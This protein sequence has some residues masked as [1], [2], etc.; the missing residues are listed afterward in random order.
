MAGCQRGVSPQLHIP[1]AAKWS[2]LPLLG[3]RFQTFGCGLLFC[4]SQS[5]TFLLWSLLLNEIISWQP[6]QH[7][8]EPFS[9]SSGISCQPWPPLALTGKVACRLAWFQPCI[10]WISS[11][12]GD[13][14]HLF[15]LH[16]PYEVF[17]LREALE[18]FES[19]LSYM[20]CW[21]KI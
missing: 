9:F 19:H 18:L 13:K 12:F 8:A 16:N 17:A 5:C 21:L 1:S 7:A 4:P 11:F 2:I 15:F 10:I 14:L 6:S 20:L 3:R